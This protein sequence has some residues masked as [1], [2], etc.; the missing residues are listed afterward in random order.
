LVSYIKR[1]TQTE[2]VR[3][4]DAENISTSEG[5]GKL[6]DGSFIICTPHLILLERSSQAGWDGQGM[7]YAYEINACSSL[8]E[9]T[10]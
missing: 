1:I 4:Q 7:Q 8:V 10:G 3:E 9:K 6:H 2:C 5:W